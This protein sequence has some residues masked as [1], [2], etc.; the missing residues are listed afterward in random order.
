MEIN[1]SEQKTIIIKKRYNTIIITKDEKIVLTNH[2]E[3]SVDNLRQK[4]FKIS[5]L[6]YSLE[7]LKDY[8]GET[9]VFYDGINMVISDIL[10]ENNDIPRN[11]ITAIFIRSKMNGCSFDCQNYQK[12][13]DNSEGLYKIKD[14]EE[15]KI[16][17]KKTAATFKKFLSLM[18]K[19]RPDVKM[20]IL[21]SK[22]AHVIIPSRYFALYDECG[23]LLFDTTISKEEVKKIIEETNKFEIYY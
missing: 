13:F 15:D 18:K 4:H 12:K 20:N 1:N 8:Y 7:G 19:E 17:Q 14:L 23:F 22:L 10:N 2:S 5:G 11:K 21:A 9:S 3:T 16:L 6:N